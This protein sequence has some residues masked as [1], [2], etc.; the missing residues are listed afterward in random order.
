MEPQENRQ[1]PEDEIIPLRRNAASSEESSIEPESIIDSSEE[2]DIEFGLK[3]LSAHSFEWKNAGSEE[4]EAFRKRLIA[5]FVIFGVA[6]FLLLLLWFI[7][8]IM[9]KNGPRH[10]ATSQHSKTSL[11]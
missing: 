9:H 1:I 6:I 4:S 5:C 11:I 8:S 7:A 2:K 10:T 3:V